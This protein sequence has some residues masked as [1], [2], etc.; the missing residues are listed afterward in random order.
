MIHAIPVAAAALW[1]SADADEQGTDEA[2]AVP[3]IIGMEGE[4]L[5]A[6][7]AC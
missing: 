5:A 6:V 7:R 2:V 4:R 1:L 3:T